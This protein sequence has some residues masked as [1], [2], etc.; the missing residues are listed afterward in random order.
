MKILLIQFC[1]VGLLALGLT[2]LA[3]LLI[4]VVE[5]LRQPQTVRGPS[6]LRQRRSLLACIAATFVIG[7]IECLVLPSKL[8]RSLRTRPKRVA[9]ANIAEGQWLNGQK[10]YKA[11]AGLAN[12]GRYAVV[13]IGSDADHATVAVAADVGIAMGICTDEALAA[14]DSVNVA[15][16]GAFKGT[17][18]VQNS[19]AGAIAAGNL[20]VPDAGGQVKAL[21][22]G[23]GNYFI[24][25]RALGPAAAQNDR[26]PIV[27]L[28]VWKTQ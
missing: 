12:V 2:L 23:A 16:L 10:S 19:A 13:K 17:T 9:F 14:E 3:G 24:I 20:V 26:V 5:Y 21:P 6:G 15:L 27:P 25:G 28:G 11:D 1:S 22:V 8:W 4:G 7:V 18:F